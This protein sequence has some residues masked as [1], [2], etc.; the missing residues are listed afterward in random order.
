MISHDRTGAP[1]SAFPTLPATLGHDVSRWRS[2][3]RVR[4]ER[5]LAGRVG[6]HGTLWLE[7]GHVRDYQPAV[8]D[9]NRQ[10]AVYVGAALLVW[11]AMFVAGTNARNGT[12]YRIAAAMLDELLL[13]NLRCGQCGGSGL[14]CSRC[15]G[16]G[17]EPAS[18]A[19]RSDR[20][21]INP[22]GWAHRIAPVYQAAF[23]Q[24]IGLERAAVDNRAKTG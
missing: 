21:G 14:A 1:L 15:C 20:T 22:Q 7:F 3:G 16:T 13:T 2:T 11:G 19:W 23:G 10:R 24:L 12:H 5:G 8:Y 18:D 17:A 6:A 4:G 9:P